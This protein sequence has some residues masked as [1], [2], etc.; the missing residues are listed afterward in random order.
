MQADGIRGSN[1]S[2]ISTAKKAGSRSLVY[3]AK[4]T[5]EKNKPGSSEFSANLRAA[6]SIWGSLSPNVLKN[7]REL[8]ER[9]HVSVSGGDVT[10]LG[11]QLYVTHAGLL[12]ICERNRCSGIE[13]RVQKELSDPMISRWVF[14][15]TVFKSSRSKG[16]VGYGDADPSNT[17]PLVRGAEMRVAET[18][19]VNRALRK[20]YGHRPLQC[21]RAR[22]VLRSANARR[23]RIAFQWSCVREGLEQRPAAIARSAVPADSP[24]RSRSHARQGVRR[25]LLRHRYSKRC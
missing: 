21:R 16:F 1:A 4:R 11:S 14:R 10:L 22:F 23:A 13:T 5:A 17:S 25:G 3:N 18:R 7:L 20:A 8:T 2:R 24:A 15:A 12:R 9:H 19:A 6:R